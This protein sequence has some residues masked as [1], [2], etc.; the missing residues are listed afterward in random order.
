M[1]T[2]SQMVIGSLTALGLS[3]C[4]SSGEQD[5]RFNAP[6]GVNV[7]YTMTVE[8]SNLFGRYLEL[9]AQ[10]GKAVSQQDLPALLIELDENGDGMVSSES[11]LVPKYNTERE[12][13]YSTGTPETQE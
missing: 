2:L 10:N 7:A 12:R 13:A 1:K 9:R 5:F 6:G 3:A 4:L 8:D 11:E